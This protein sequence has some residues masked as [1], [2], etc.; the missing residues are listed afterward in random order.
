[1]MLN[2][3]SKDLHLHYSKNYGSLARV[4]RLKV[5]VNILH[6]LGDSSTVSNLKHAINVAFIH[7][8]IIFCS[9]NNLHVPSTDTA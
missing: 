9:D 3:A 7:S 2:F 5:A 6:V 8:V 4:T 1:M